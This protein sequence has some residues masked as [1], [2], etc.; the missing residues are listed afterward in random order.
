MLHSLANVPLSSQQHGVGASGC[1][2]G[3]LVQGEA[4][5]AGRG[6]AFP[7]S[8]GET[9]GGDGELGNLGQ[10]LVVQHGA[11]S[12]DGLGVVGVGSGSVLDNLREGD[13][14]SVDLFCSATIVSRA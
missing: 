9:E 13:R 10:T 8:G 1:T 5:T 11:D 14:G 12:D 2:Q 3:E 7:G 6:D 4:L